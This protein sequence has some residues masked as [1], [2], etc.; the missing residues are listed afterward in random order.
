MIIVFALSSIEY[1]SHNMKYKI[2]FWFT[3]VEIMVVVAVIGLLA[4][5][6]IPSF[7][8]A[9]ITSQNT[10]FAQQ[11]RTAAGAFKQA[12][13]TEGDY[14]PDVS[15]GVMPEGM[16]DHLQDFPWAQETPI[17]GQWDW[18]Y[19]VFGYKAG[20][21]VCNPEADEDRM[22]NIDEILDDGNLDSGQ[23]RT[24]PEGYIYI[25]ESSQE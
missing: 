17:G 9:G 25:I 24:R 22:K 15:R 6:A 8:K 19:E 7:M 21:S 14:P 12:C 23:F 18:D 5:I 20:V 11:I 10:T 1:Y 16:E 3:L 4:A 2:T 13:I